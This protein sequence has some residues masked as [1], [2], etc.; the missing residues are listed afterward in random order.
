MNLETFRIIKTEIINILDRFD[1]LEKSG[2]DYKPYQ[3]EIESKTKRFFELQSQLLES[4]LSSIPFEEWKGLA[5]IVEDELDLSKTHANIDFSLLRYIYYDTINLDGC[6]IRGLE[7]LHFDENTFSEDFIRSHPDLFPDETVPKELRDKFFRKVLHFTDLIKCPSLKKWINKNS[8]GSARYSLSSQLVDAIG[9]D[10]ALK[11]FDEH[12]DFIVFITSKS[13]GHI[14]F[15][16]EDFNKDASYEETKKSVYQCVLKSLKKNYGMEFPPFEIIPP[17][18]KEQIP[19]LFI[20][21]GQLPE[22]IV[23]DYYKGQLSI[24]AVRYYSDVLQTKEIEVGIRHN[25]YYRVLEK[26]FGSIW[27]Y[28]NKM[29]VEFDYIVSNYISSIYN[30]DEIEHMKTMQPEEIIASAIRYLLDTNSAYIDIDDVSVFC[31]YIPLDEVIANKIIRDFILKCGLPILQSY[32]KKNNYI[33]DH[34]TSYYRGLESSLLGHIAKYAPK[35]EEDIIISSEEDL[36]IYFEKILNEMRK[37]DDYNIAFILKNN[38]KA[39]ALIYPNLFID[40]TLV[41]TVLNALPET[42]R[43]EVITQLELGINGKTDVLLKVLNRYPILLPVIENKDIVIEENIYY[44]E[45]LE[46]LG[47]KKFLEIAAKYGEAIS[48]LITNMM[49]NDFEVFL[50][51]LQNAENIEDLLNIKIYE[52]ITSRRRFDIRLLPSSFKKMHPE[53]YLNASAPERL[54]NRFYGDNR[55]IMGEMSVLNMNDLQENPEWINYLIHIDL[56]KCLE[57]KLISVYDSKRSSAPHYTQS[58]SLY[59]ALSIVFT[60]EEILSMLSQYGTFLWCMNHISVDLGAE[61]KECYEKILRQIYREMANRTVAIRKDMPVE[62]KQKYPDLFLDENAPEELQN[63]FYQRRINPELIELHPEWIPFLEAKNLNAV[64]TSYI[65]NFVSDATD[66]KLSNSKIFE[67][68]IKYGKYLSSCKVRLTPDELNN[69]DD[70]IKKQIIEAII[71]NRSP[72][73]ESAKDIIGVERPDLFLDENAPEELKQFFYNSSTNTPLTFELLKQYKEWLPFLKNKNVL[74]SLQKKNRGARGLAQLF[75]RYG[76]EKAIAIGLKNP[77]SVMKMMEINKYELFFQWYDKL[78][79]VPHHVV[80]IDFPVEQSDK[81]LA[82]GKKWSQLMRIERHN[83]NEESKS[84]L[85]KASMC[86]GV[87]DN[88]MEGFNKTMQLFTEVPRSLSEE[89]MDYLI[90]I[91]E[92]SIAEAPEDVSVDYLK[93]LELLK[94]AYSKNDT[95]SYTLCINPQQNKTEISIIRGMMER[96]EFKKVLTPDLAHKLF[97]GF[98]MKYDPDFRDF[99]LDNLEVILQ[100]DEYISYISS[101]QKQWAEIRAL[102]SNRVL[103]LDLALAYVKSNNYQQVQTGNERLAEIANQA[104]YSQADF[105]TLQMIY[106][107]GKSRI[108]NSIPRIKAT[109]G[110]YTY[111]VLR[112]DDPLALAI[113]T[114]TD[115]CQE[116]GNAAETSMQHSM[117]DKHGRIF[118]IKDDAGNI[119]AQSWMW[120]N[121]NVVCFDNI[122]IPAKAFT[123]AERSGITREEF[124][125][126]IYRLYQQAGQELIAKDEQTYAQLLEI[127]KITEE[128]Y[129]ALKLGKITV[130]T[131]YNDIADA[132][133][134]NAEKDT[135]VVARPI[136]FFPPVEL[137]HGLYT[138]DSSS[139]YVIAGNADVVSSSIHTPAV[140]PDEFIIYDDTNTKTSDALTLQKLEYITN[141][142]H[143]IGRTQ[144][145]ETENIVS[146]IA[147]NYNL[148]PER[149]RIIMNANFA[150][151]YEIRK[152]DIVIADL[153]YNTSI[154]NAGQVIDITE[155]VVMQI[156]MALEQIGFKGKKFNLD[157]LKKEQLEMCEKAMRLDK[158]I[159]EERGFS[160]GTR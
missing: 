49:S 70:S 101:M 21:D 157:R 99:I 40:Y 138:S 145:S 7:A 150:I 56:D 34:G 83:L 48:V 23:S 76:A 109:S 74:L 77:E 54:V 141:P 125:D 116:L 46:V 139:Q 122:E 5:L 88:D 95:G 128:Q 20:D 79:F 25:S 69:L 137:A 131:G 61:K 153:L 86:F 36:H 155:Q 15:A 72:Y 10:M 39:L 67:L 64:C 136:Q 130:G 158:E 58:M 115:C 47:T 123:R 9:L 71:Y 75:A 160:Y 32:N 80:M 89:E 11:L 1:A 63:L 121:K 133:K 102:N 30:N 85:L 18:M 90:N 134:R 66:I 146:D 6:N 33:F 59:K 154:N 26:V 152:E 57:S 106:N 8:F 92:K 27:N 105:D 156:R 45:L 97:G 127:G 129:E 159:D 52:T 13:N 126:T 82:A 135:S 2:E 147:Y 94:M 103:T 68:F 60:Q 142:D 118:V 120:R 14:A 31:N 3:S 113:G 124:T 108:F 117:V 42:Q 4:D 24:N 37:S 55:Y 144:S 148:N 29:P 12:P 93:E 91:L 112:L 84:A 19:S 107:F 16:R 53:L 38:K 143:Y 110:V 41:E 22:E 43:E 35:V 119:V 96:V 50:D 28:I 44:K 62:F 51:E 98:V 65:L 87:F 73:D 104:G 149:T 151:I 111:E 17:E 81:F 132:L 114:L 78:N 140:Y 100:S